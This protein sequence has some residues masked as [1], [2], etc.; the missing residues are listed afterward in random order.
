MTFILEVQW[1][2]QQGWAQPFPSPLIERELCKPGR[3][4]QTQVARPSPAAPPPKPA[5]HGPGCRPRP[6][7]LSLVL[8]SSHVIHRALAPVVAP[9]SPSRQPAEEP[10]QQPLVLMLPPALPVDAPLTPPAVPLRVPVARTTHSADAELEARPFASELSDGDLHAAPP[11]P[12]A[13]GKLRLWETHSYPGWFFLLSAVALCVLWFSGHT[14][15]KGRLPVMG[16]QEGMCRGVCSRT[17]AIRKKPFYEPPSPP[18]FPPPRCAT[19]R[20]YYSAEVI[21]MRGRWEP[22]V[23]QDHRYL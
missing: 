11:P 10:L 3:Q 8:P 20:S 21:V 5:S 22:A 6:N 9:P 23:A 2:K 1:S 17:E 12:A 14:L 4:Q 7:Q 18:L 15:A 19:S 16:D 13:R